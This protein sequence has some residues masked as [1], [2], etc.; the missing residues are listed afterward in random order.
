VVGVVSVQGMSSLC[1]DR[2]NVW[3]EVDH[4]PPAVVVVEDA[5]GGPCWMR[6]GI[7]LTVEADQNRVESRLAA[8][9]IN[10]PTCPGVLRSWGWARPR[11]VRGVAGL[12]RPRRARCRGCLVTHVL[13]PVT[14][15]SRRAY[16]VEVIGAALTA[17]ASGCG[18][19]PIGAALD[20]PAATVRGWLRVMAARA[21]AVRLFLWQVAARAGVDQLVPEALGS[22]W[23]DLLAALGAAMVAVRGRFGLV[24]VLGPVTPWQVAAACSGARLLAPGWPPTGPGCGGNTS[25]P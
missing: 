19:R 20:V 10:C 15:L 25:S 11:G 6:G 3:T 1:W 7:V 24:G 13:L 8:G 14:T 23:R 18:H 12:L 21:E 4:G 17:R 5:A 22:P 16:G 9:E 2:E